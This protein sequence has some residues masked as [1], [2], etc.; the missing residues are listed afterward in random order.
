MLTFFNPAHDVE[1]LGLF[2][3]MLLLFSIFIHALIFV[4]V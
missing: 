1:S 3:I 2:L 4:V